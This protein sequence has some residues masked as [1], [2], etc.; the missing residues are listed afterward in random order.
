VAAAVKLLHQRAPALE[1]DGEMHGD[2][3]LDA[4]IRDKTSPDYL[5]GYA[6]SRLL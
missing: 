4:D 1:V 6:A 2:A 5:T 3:A